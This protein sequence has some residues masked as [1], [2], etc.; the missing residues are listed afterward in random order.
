MNDYSP[1]VL[2]DSK[3]D[4][5]EWD[6]KVFVQWEFPFVDI[7]PTL[8]AYGKVSTNNLTE[9]TL[10]YK[11][12]IING[13]CEK[14]YMQTGLTTTNLSNSSGNFSY[15][16]PNVVI[17]WT[18]ATPVRKVT[19]VGRDGEYPTKVDIILRNSGTLVLNKVDQVLT[20][21]FSVVDLLANYTA[22]YMVISIKS[23]S[24]PNAS[25]KLL[26][27]N[28]S[29]ITAFT[30]D[31]IISMTVDE[32]I[33]NGSEILIGS[34]E[35]K[36]LNLVLDN[37]E[38]RFDPNSSSLY[39][40]LLNKN[41]KL[42]VFLGLKS[43][44]DD[45]E[46]FDYLPMGT[47]YAEEWTPADTM[48]QI[49]VR[50]LD[51]LATLEDYT[52]NYSGWV[53]GTHPVL[54]LKYFEHILNVLLPSKGLNLP[55]SVLPPDAFIYNITSQITDFIG[56]TVR[57]IFFYFAERTNSFCVCSK[58]GHIR[59]V[60]V[61]YFYEQAQDTISDENYFIIK[62]NFD[63]RL[64]KNIL[65]LTAMDLTYINKT[66]SSDV[67]KYGNIEYVIE[68]NPAI[69]NSTENGNV[70]TSIGDISTSII[71]YPSIEIEWQGCP[72]WE[73]LDRIAI[74]NLGIEFLITS[75]HYEYNGGLRC[76]TRGRKLI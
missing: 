66:I 75:N 57:E 9:A 33:E 2:Y 72:A 70:S 23:W 4:L 19:I 14:I 37:S 45:Q 63:K 25:I 71:F 69:K 68:E 6:C 5:R 11:N 3:N 8:G 47:Y 65:K 10:S 7:E 42:I 52:F 1:I 44:V 34:V 76:T 73:I 40:N 30:N 48:T 43:I 36:S 17:D 15:P 39:G 18:N 74:S 16:Y 56:K 51:L 28:P 21:E 59:F 27:T 32:G 46:K 60:D 13:V 67:K 12:Q 53:G 26:Q 41:V 38:N 29:M 50:A 20:S 62:N 58:D 35:A 31:D 24:A 55:L 61:G 54:L 64:T 22:N 49:T